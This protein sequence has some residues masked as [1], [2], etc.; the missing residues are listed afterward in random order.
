LLNFCAARIEFTANA[1]N[2]LSSAWAPLSL[3]LKSLFCPKASFVRI[4]A[5]VSIAIVCLFWRNEL[6]QEGVTVRLDYTAHSDGRLSYLDLE[7]SGL[8]G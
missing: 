1:A 5:A 3:D 2:V 6:A 8:A 4:A 7:Y